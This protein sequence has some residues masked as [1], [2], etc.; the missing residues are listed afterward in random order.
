MALLDTLNAIET[1]IETILT[2]TLSYSLEDLSVNDIE[3]K[4]LAQLNAGDMDILD[5]EENSIEY[6]DRDYRIDTKSFATSPDEA[7]D[8]ANVIIAAVRAAFTIAALNS[9]DFAV[10]KL[11]VSIT[12]FSFPGHRWEGKTVH[13]DCMFRINFNA[14]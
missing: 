12:G 5:D 11:V 6:A 9:G 3:D 10:S 2:A 8:K 13:Q 4:T 14:E 7:R 1:N